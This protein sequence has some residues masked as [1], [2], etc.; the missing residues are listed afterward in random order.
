MVEDVREAFGY[1]IFQRGDL[2][3]EYVLNVGANFVLL[4][5]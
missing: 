2:I 3:S 5:F 4:E 1:M